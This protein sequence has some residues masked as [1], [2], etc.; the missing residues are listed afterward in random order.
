[1]GSSLFHSK[2]GC[3]GNC[4]HHW[5]ARDHRLLHQFKATPRRQQKEMRRYIQPLVGG[6]A[7]QFVQRIVPTN[8]VAH[9]LDDPIG[10]AQG[11][12]MGGAG[13]PSQYLVLTQGGS[14]LKNCIRIDV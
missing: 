9:Q 3:G 13:Q 4:D 12:G 6:S 1:M 10:A 8:I 2:G 14:R 11:R 7:Q 5:C